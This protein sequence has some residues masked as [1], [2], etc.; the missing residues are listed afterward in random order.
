MQEYDRDRNDLRNVIEDQRRI[1]VR[2]PTP[3]RRSLA[4]DVAI[5]GR[6]NFHALEGPL[7]EVR[8]LDKFKADN[9]DRYDGSN[10]PEEFIQVYL[11]VIEATGGDNRIKANF[12]PVALTDA[13]DHGLSTCQKDPSTLGTS[14][15]PC[16]SGTSRACTSVHLLLRP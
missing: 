15:V 10:N 12:L 6:S 16:L 8:P 4:G 13:V 14:Y 3:L 5:V 1:R 7:K 2:N 11:T 9:I